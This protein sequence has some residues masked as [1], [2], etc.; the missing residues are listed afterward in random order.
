MHNTI[1]SCLKWY[2]HGIDTYH[3]F[4][5]QR[6]FQITRISCNPVLYAFDIEHT[7]PHTVA[8]VFAC[9]SS[10][11]ISCTQASLPLLLVVANLTADSC[12]IFSSMTASHNAEL[13]LLRHFTLVVIC[14]NMMEH[15]Y[16]CKRQ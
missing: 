2:L 16:D 8:L 6:D 5:L 4:P 11:T 3:K 9:T 1:P 13:P 15:V 10:K 12:T 14:L 7:G